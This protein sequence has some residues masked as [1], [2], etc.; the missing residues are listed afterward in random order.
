MKKII[1]FTLFLF[2]AIGISSC[3]SATIVTTVEQTSS[4]IDTTAQLTENTTTVMDTTT[5]YTTISNEILVEQLINE[6][7]EDYND[8]SDGFSCETY[9][10]SELIDACDT[11]SEYFAPSK[12]NSFTIIDSIETSGED[13]VLEYTYTTSTNIV[14][15]YVEF[16]VGLEYVSDSL[17][18]TSWENTVIDN[19]NLTPDQL[20]SY[21]FLYEY[22]DASIDHNAFS[23][24]WINNQFDA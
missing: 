20:I 5:E 13:N 18:I 22:N 11:Q 2:T 23:S 14:T 8:Q 9:F 21:D 4:L 19:P 1:Y 24:K 15:D 6:M 17:L 12:Y 7:L 16:V 3:D 10:N